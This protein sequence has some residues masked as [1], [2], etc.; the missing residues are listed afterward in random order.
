V[1]R[2][3]L[4][5]L[6]ERGGPHGIR[7]LWLAEDA[8]LL[9]AACRSFVTLAHGS[10][11]GAAGFPATGESVEPLE[12]ESLDEA[13][14]LELARRLAR[15]VDIGARVHDASDLPRSVS[16]LTVSDPPLAP[17]AEAVIERWSQN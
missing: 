5:E 11:T 12:T 14:A 6:A 1:E 8:A 3:R 4:V 10:V 16:L 13:T 2:S 7:V 15:L 17:A 9:P